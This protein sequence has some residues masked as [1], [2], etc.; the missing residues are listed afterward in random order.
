MTPQEER[1]FTAILERL[2]TEQA[3]WEWSR[4]RSLHLVQALTEPFV[5]GVWDGY[6]NSIAEIEA[7]RKEREAGGDE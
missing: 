3:Q 6:D 7:L 4:V 1:L 5:R 2:R